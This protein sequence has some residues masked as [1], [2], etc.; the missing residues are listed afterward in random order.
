MALQ[1]TPA[2]PLADVDLEN[3]PTVD[4]TEEDKPEGKK[5]TQGEV[6]DEIDYLYLMLS[7]VGLSPD[8]T[9]GARK[10]M[11]L[12]ETLTRLP[13]ND[14]PVKI[15]E[16]T[17]APAADTTAELTADQINAIAADLSARVRAVVQTEMRRLK[18]Q[19]D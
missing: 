4:L 3:T 7:E 2:N 13:G 9:D 17:P 12:I 11:T 1:H 5:L 16:P 19:L 10:L 18:G 14:I 6:K 15:A 8:N